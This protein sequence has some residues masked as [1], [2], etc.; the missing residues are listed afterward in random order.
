MPL[1]ILALEIIKMKR[2][3]ITLVVLSLLAFATLSVIPATAADKPVV[4]VHLKGALE[5]DYQLRALMNTSWVE[6]SVVYED[7]AAADLSGASMLIM[8]LG[9]S[10]QVYSAD[11]LSA[12]DSW[13]TG[14]KT[15]YIAADSDYGTDHLRQYQANA[16]LEKLGSK[17]RID[18]ASVE[19]ATSNGGAPYRV[20][21]IS[22]N[23]ASEFEYL[24]A[25]VD[26]G[27]FH[28]PAVVVGY[29][30]GSYVDLS[31]DS[32]DDVYV[33]MTTSSDGI[34]VDNNEPVPNVVVAGTEGEFP[35][36][37]LEKKDGNTIIA[38]GDAPF[39]QYMGL[40]GPDMLRADRYG[41]DANPQ[42]GM[43]LVE[44]ILR[45][46]T[47]FGDVIRTQEADISDNEAAIASNEAEIAGLE[48]DVDD[49]DDEVSSLES[50]VSSLE[51]DV[52]ALESDKTGLEADVAAAQSS[53][54]TMQL[55]AVAALVIGVVVGYFVGP[56]IKKD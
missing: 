5:A 54:S 6:W 29:D 16:V 7:I 24:V 33:I 20:L 40:Y 27:L 50:D 3:L 38:A 25:G 23:V 13:F 26:R 48:D 12:V 43:Y 18:D 39:G 21:G 8:V 42:Q 28:G 51:S 55:A 46:A 15:I 37:V 9:D 53:A 2:K 36:M 41:A 14:G 1:D 35:V 4:V 52:S 19:D 31:E 11:E 56:M 30:G 22:D 47:S 17:I 49:L 34:I 10:S 32:V 44:N 45:Y